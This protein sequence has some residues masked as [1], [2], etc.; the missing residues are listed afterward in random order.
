MATAESA[1]TDKI[2]SVASNEDTVHDC[3]S[4]NRDSSDI[5][6]KCSS[7]QFTIDESDPQE[8]EP[9]W[10][11]RTPPTEDD[12]RDYLERMQAIKKMEE[13]G[14]TEQLPSN[15]ATTQLETMMMNMRG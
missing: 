13:D 10:M 3:L 7:Q 4:S 6:F 12:I 1:E 8:T 2:E 9:G 5:S 11:W 15:K 14:S